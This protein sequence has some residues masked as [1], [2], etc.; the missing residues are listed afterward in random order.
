VAQPTE[1][2][3][4]C[5]HRAGVGGR[6]GAGHP[7]VACTAGVLGRVTRSFRC[8]AR[9]LGRVTRSPKPVDRSERRVNRSILVLR[10]RGG[11]RIGYVGNTCTGD[12]GNSR[13]TLFTHSRDDVASSVHVG[14]RVARPCRQCS[15][16]GRHGSADL[17]AKIERDVSVFGDVVAAPH[18]RRSFRKS[19]SSVE[20]AIR[21]AHPT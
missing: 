10:I 2:S 21:I 17:V 6:A 1:L 13:A 18:A 14:A 11:V 12:V 7:L 4:G 16:A 3:V 5:L 19:R 9:I 20:I 15:T 8:A